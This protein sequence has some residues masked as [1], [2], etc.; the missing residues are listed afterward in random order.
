[1]AFV[2]AWRSAGH[3]NLVGF[4]HTTVRFWDLRC[5]FDPKSL[6]EYRDFSRPLPDFWAVNGELANRNMIAGG[7]PKDR[8]IDV[9]ALRYLYL[10]RIESERKS[11][12]DK[13][14]KRNVVLFGDYSEE[15]NQALLLDWI[16]PVSRL[17]PGMFRFIFKGHPGYYFELSEELES[18]VEFSD[19]PISSVLG[20]ADIVVSSSLTSAIAEAY[21]LGI[22]AIELNSGADLNFSPL[23]GYPG[24]FRASNLGE[25][26]SILQ[27][28]PQ[29]CHSTKRDIFHIDENLT[30]WQKL[31]QKH[32]PEFVDSGDSSL[33]PIPGRSRLPNI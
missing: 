4:L 7:F 3:G 20:I 9:E 25:L 27:K 31:L 24:V 16:I 21:V 28:L 10:G 23:I 29:E 12:I 18:E 14:A 8:L 11:I 22:P 32:I 13:Q 1:M 17:C 19:E 33:L 15:R 30:R 5:F 26:L 6:T 2:H